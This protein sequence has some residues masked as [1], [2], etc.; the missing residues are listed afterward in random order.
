MSD[1]VPRSNTPLALSQRRDLSSNLGI[2]Q[3]TS[4]FF[5]VRRESSHFVSVILVWSIYIYCNQ[6]NFATVHRCTRYTH[7]RDIWSIR[8]AHLSVSRSAVAGRGDL[9]SILGIATLFGCCKHS[10]LFFGF[11]ALCH[12]VIHVTHSQDSRLSK[13]LCIKLMRVIPAILYN[14]LA[15]LSTAGGVIEGRVPVG[16]WE[17]NPRSNRS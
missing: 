10:A 6:R 1:R 2:A 17:S 13:R 9:S 7:F 4:F 5:T 8:P 11:S 3:S 14:C 12:C 16:S 15:R